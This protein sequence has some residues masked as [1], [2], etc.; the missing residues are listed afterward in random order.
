MPN[1]IGVVLEGGRNFYISNSGW[2]SLRDTGDAVIRAGFNLRCIQFSGTNEEEIA[3]EIMA[4]HVDGLIW[5]DNIE[6]SESLVER[7]AEAGLPVVCDKFGFAGDNTVAYDTFSACYEIG[8]ELAERDVSSI[9][10]CLPRWFAEHDLPMM[11]KAY[12]DTGKICRITRSAP[13][14]NLDFFE[15]YFRKEK[16]GVVIAHCRLHPFLRRLSKKNG[17]DFQILDRLQGFS[18]KYA[19]PH[20]ERARLMLVRLKELMN[21]KHGLDPLMI[22]MKF[23]KYKQQKETTE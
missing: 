11:E 10:F 17:S 14:E 2:K 9:L 4:N 5:I 15:E 3:E 22:P 20:K 18:G 21:G 6:L 13:R 1:L 7:L 8:K 12:Q 23:I 19:F 16:K